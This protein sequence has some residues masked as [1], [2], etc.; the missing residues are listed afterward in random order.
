MAYCHT[1][2]KQFHSLGIMRHRAMHRDKKQDCTIT[3]KSG[4]YE[5]KYSGK[6]IKINIPNYYVDL[7]EQRKARMG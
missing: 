1:C 4:T 3:L 5:Y 7:V 2:A 6:R